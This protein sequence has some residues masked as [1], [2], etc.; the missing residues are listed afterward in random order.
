[1]K[2]IPAKKSTSAKRPQLTR[3]MI[4]EKA[5][6]LIDSNGL[7]SLSMRSLGKALNVEAMSLYHHF[8]NKGK[9]LDA[10]MECLLDETHW[11]PRGS[12]PPIERIR[13]FLKTYQQLVVNHPKAFILLVYRRFNTEQTFEL[14]E[15]FLQT[16]EDLGLDAS[17]SARFFRFF[18]Y[19]INGAGMAYIASHAA[20]PDATP[21]QL[22]DFKFGERFPH[23]AAVAP[24]LRMNNLDNIYQFGL[25][26][27]FSEL[28]K[29]ATKG[30]EK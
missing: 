23:V 15:E 20:Q 9:V 2:K 25:D 28:E 27:I 24:H 4:A 19:Y 26:V 7:E 3:R 21:V 22:E 12:M 17:T 6:E 14:Y 29:H 10:V 30:L 18:G 5:L 8:D 1:M 11:P 13:Q 16:F